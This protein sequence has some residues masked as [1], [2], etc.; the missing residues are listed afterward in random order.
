MCSMRS[1]AYAV[2]DHDPDRPWIVVGEIRHLTVQLQ[3]DRNFF[4]WAAREWPAPR[5]QVQL[6]PWQLS[7]DG[8]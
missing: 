3:D 8:R 7:P 1:Y 6:E 5:Y 2:T 4:E